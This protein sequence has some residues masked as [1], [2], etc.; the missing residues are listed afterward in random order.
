MD[1][2]WLVYQGAEVLD[3]GSLK[4]YLVHFAS[5]I[6]GGSPEHANSHHNRSL[7]LIA[8]LLPGTQHEGLEKLAEN[9]LFW[10]LLGVCNAKPKLA[11]CSTASIIH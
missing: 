11:L 9:I 1:Q 10:R 7:A 3:K 2:A 8:S 5:A 6:A 4:H